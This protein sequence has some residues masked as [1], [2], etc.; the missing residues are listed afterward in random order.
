MNAWCS[1]EVRGDVDFLAGLVMF[2]GELN[3]H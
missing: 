3:L 1:F 2:D